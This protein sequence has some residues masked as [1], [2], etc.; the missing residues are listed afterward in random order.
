MDY[1]EAAS[2]RELALL[3]V[4]VH[5]VRNIWKMQASLFITYPIAYP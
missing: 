5:E 3:E 1:E 4:C 2:G